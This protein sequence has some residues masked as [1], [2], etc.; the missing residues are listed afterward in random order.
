[1]L[2]KFLISK[3]HE[4]KFRKLVQLTRSFQS[5]PTIL[6]AVIFSIHTIYNSS[7]RSSLEKEDIPMKLTRENQQS[8]G[9]R[10]AG[11]IDP[12]IL[13]KFV[14]MLV[15]C[16]LQYLECRILEEESGRLRL[17]ETLPFLDGSNLHL[18]TQV[19]F[20]STYASTRIAA[21]VSCPLARSMV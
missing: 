21:L 14:K 17:L 8:Q 12:R 20:F 13:S 2:K 4:H 10:D 19:N 9:L 1:M 11:C 15:S 18:Y 6:F 16:M 5:S 7:N 3:L